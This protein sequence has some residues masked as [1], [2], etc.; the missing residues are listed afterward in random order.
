MLTKRHTPIQDTRSD[1]I[2]NALNYSLLCILLIITAYPLILVLSA[3]ISDPDAVMRG[4]VWLF[5][6]GFSLEGYAAVF[7][8]QMIL[9]GYANT[10]YYVVV[11]TA[12]N[13]FMTIIAAYPL[14]RKDLVGRKV[15]LFVFSFTMLF[16]GGL[17][18]FYLVVR[19]L[20]LMDTRWAL[21]IPSAMSV[22][23]VLV[24]RSYFMTNI[25][26]ELLEAAKMDGC[27]DI[28]FL[29]K[30]VVPLS[31]PII[32]VMA[33]FY[34]VGH[35]NSY[36]NALIFLNDTAKYPLQLVLRQILVLNQVSFDMLAQDPKA[37]EIKLKLMDVLK[38][39][40]IIIANLP[41]FIAY[42]FVQK[43]FVKGIMVGSVKG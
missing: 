41:L 18:P 2:F 35:W 42:P 28:K 12:L 19:D 16:G 17:I 33:L 38:Y 22:Y 43:Y 26:G 21:I 7:K 9:M 40:V 23:N 15:I 39:S 13:I 14:S 4:Q 20:H 24:M 37:L 8:N 34:G 11:G 36:F 31:G 29:T 25:P 5:P 30:V 10:I 3:S 27:T 6:V 32:A 1:K